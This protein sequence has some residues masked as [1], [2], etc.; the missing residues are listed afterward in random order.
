[1]PASAWLAHVKK[2]HTEMKKK[3]SKATLGDA[4]KEAKKTY[5]KK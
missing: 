1:M 5:K 4:M 3:N 2:V